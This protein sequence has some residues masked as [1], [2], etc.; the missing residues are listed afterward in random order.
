MEITILKEQF[1]Q[2]KSKLTYDISED[3]KKMSNEKLFFSNIFFHIDQNN[4]DIIHSIYA[5]VDG[6]ILS[7]TIFVGTSNVNLSDLTLEALLH[8]KTEID[9]FNKNKLITENNY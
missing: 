1:Y 3:L 4:P 2:L 7:D 5:I 9:F 6:N 8:I